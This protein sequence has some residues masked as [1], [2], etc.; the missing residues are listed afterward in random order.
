MKHIFSHL[1][2]LA[3]FALPLQ[4]SGA[5]E[6][7]IE[8]SECCDDGSYYL[9]NKYP[10]KM[11]VGPEIY[12]VH[13]TREGGSKQKGWIYGVKAGYDHIKRY[14]FYW[15][16]DLLWGQGPLHG[17]S[18][19]TK[20]KSTF[21]DAAA[22]GRLGYTFQNK[23]F[24]HISFTPFVGYGYFQETNRFHRNA[25]LNI[26]FKNRF[27]YVAAGFFSSVE[28]NPNMSVGLNFKAKFPYETKCSV[29]DPEFGS[30][31]LSVKDKTHYRIE[32]PIAYWLCKCNHVFEFDLIPFFEYRQYGR[33][34]NFPF[35]F[36]DT[37]LRIYGVSFQI[38]YRL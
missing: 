37:K 12:H 7:Y 18:V 5:D 8:N 35:D 15:G 4:Y 22:E 23:C 2:A 1:I 31:T 6:I 33:R 27:Q 17:K 26:K 36:L 19:L 3:L 32:L 28:L 20:L 13:R 29:S 16:G 25:P 34:E 24:R 30:T 21:T 11:Y 38:A 14:K 9:P 10:H